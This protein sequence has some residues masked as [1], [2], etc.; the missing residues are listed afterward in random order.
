MNNAD[1]AGQAGQA[2]GLSDCEGIRPRFSWEMDAEGA[3]PSTRPHVRVPKKR[4]TRSEAN[5]VQIE[6]TAP[7]DGRNPL[8]RARPACEQTRSDVGRNA[9]LLRRAVPPPIPLLSRS[10]ERATGGN[11]ERCCPR[12]FLARNSRTKGKEVSFFRGLEKGEGGGSSI[13]K[14]SIWS[15]SVKL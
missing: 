8:D 9:I 5:E 6:Q 12:K 4:A 10:V 15:Y 2:A 11:G 3:P 14:V 7:R 13:A 1:R